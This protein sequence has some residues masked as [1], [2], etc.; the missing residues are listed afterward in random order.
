M[1]AISEYKHTHEEIWKEGGRI[2]LKLTGA[3]AAV[4]MQWTGDIA[5]THGRWNRV[6][7]EEFEVTVTDGDPSPSEIEVELSGRQVFADSFE[8]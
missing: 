6:T 7:I 1:I 5:I 2:S 3:D 4:N 8:Y